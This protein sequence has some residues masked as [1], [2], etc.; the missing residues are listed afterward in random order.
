[1]S[2]NFQSRVCADDTVE[3]G[4]CSQPITCGSVKSNISYPFWGANR[5]E[6]CGKSG[7]EVTCEANVPMITMRNIKFRILDMSN[8]STTTTTPTVKVARQD[9]WETICPLTYVPTNLDTSLFDYSS[10]LLSVSFWYGCNS[11]VTVTGNSYRCNSSV[12]ASYL[13]QTRASGILVDP[14]TTGACQ[15]K[16]LVPVF[17]SASVALDN[18][19]TDIEIAIDGGF[20]L[21]VL[22]ADTELCNEC[23]KSGGVCGTIAKEFKC[24]CQTTSSSTATCT[25][26]S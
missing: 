12:T 25:E 7:F 1:M 21:D 11:N 5:P 6:Y 14:V 3:Y 24:F 2:I 9:Y 18:N 4:N 8:S 20:E 26:S 15:Y 17:E 23:L 22:N 10:G 19:A 13:T 16:V